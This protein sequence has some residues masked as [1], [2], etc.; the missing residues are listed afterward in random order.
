MIEAP[1]A[2]LDPNRSKS[3]SEAVKVVFVVEDDHDLQA[4]LSHNL[5]KEGYKVI[6]FDKAED[7]LRV[8]ESSTNAGPVAV[9]MDVNLSGHMNGMEAVRFLRSQKTTSGIP[10]LMLTAR[11]E[12]NDVVR[13]LEEGADD[14]LAKPFDMPVLIARLKS[15]FKRAQ[16]APGPV[17]IPKHKFEAAGIEVDPAAHRVI[18][19]G[20]DVELTVTEFNILFWLMQRPGEVYNRE[21]LLFRI[22][23]PNSTVTDR[24]IDVHIRALR[25][26]LGRKAKNITTVRGLGYKF[27]P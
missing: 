24:T 6:C 11:G 19:A 14:Y 18:I 17:Q 27:V 9:V 16:R 2:V 10:V 8:V 26:K 1:N 22:V 25:T 20:K 23:G 13:G 21:D 5:Q 7:F 4:I 3:P 12:S 15:V